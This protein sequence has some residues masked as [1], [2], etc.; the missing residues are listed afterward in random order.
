[1]KNRFIRSHVTSVIILL[2]VLIFLGGV[3]VA[4]QTFFWARQEVNTE[5]DKHLWELARTVD[6][7][8]NVVLDRCRRELSGLIGSEYLTAA[9]EQYCLSG[10]SEE[11][12]SVLKKSAVLLT[13]YAERIVVFEGNSSVLSTDEKDPDYE[14]LVESDGDDLWLSLDRKTGKSYLALSCE[15]INSDLKYYVLVNLTPFFERVVADIMYEDY[16][17]VLYDRGSG[18]ALQNDLYQPEYNV[19]TEDAILERNDGYTEIYK[20]EESGALGT[21]VYDFNDRE[22]GEQ[23]I[24]IFV[25]PSA[26]T[27]N[28]ILTVAVAAYNEHFSVPL[29]KM[30]INYILASVMVA[31]ST[32]AGAGF[33]IYS[34]KKA[35]DLAEEV[36]ALAKEK[37]LSDEL[38]RNQEQLI[39]HQ[40]LE[41]IGTLTAGIAHEFNNL[42]SPIMG[43]SMVILEK[44]RVSEPETFES[45]LEIYQASEKA[46]DLVTQ[47]SRLSRRQSVALMKPLSPEK[48]I[49]DVILMSEAS[50]PGNIIVE[51]D[52]NTDMMI[53][54]DEGQ[55]GHMLL[56]LVINAVQAM[57]QSDGILTVSATND[58]NNVY[59]SVSDTGCGIPEENLLTIFDP[60]FTTKEVG[61]GTGLGLAISQRIATNHGGTITAEN[62]PE[63]GARFTFSTH[64]FIQ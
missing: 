19:F 13:D 37:Q 61:K 20:R 63:G 46:K 12:E 26:E 42:L 33:L 36:A 10:D 5:H 49:S 59:I 52:I 38:L 35:R 64:I 9:E 43:Y 14:I 7:N 11:L 3:L 55:L 54:G 39:H 45:A 30:N 44:S 27:E 41:T 21:S 29:K 24:R 23:E 17:V 53:L 28:E 6:H 22:G 8:I 1:M 4:T 18:L 2:M 48:L 58:R 31:F 40:K 62:R 57:S 16:W 47:I 32:A 15:S 25:I 34:R 60:F 51:K 56:N 50:I